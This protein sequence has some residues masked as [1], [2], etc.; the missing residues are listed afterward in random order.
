MWKWRGFFGFWAE[1]VEMAEG[2]CEEGGRCGV[3]R[4]CGGLLWP[5]CGGVARLLRSVAAV[6]RVVAVVLHWQVVG[7]EGLGRKTRRF[8]I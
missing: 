6:L 1:M 4:V 7:L 2:F 3:V 5:C 8:E